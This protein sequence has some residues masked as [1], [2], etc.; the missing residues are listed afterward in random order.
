MTF[1]IVARC[2]ETGMLGMAVASS[3]PAVAA[4]C[5]HARAGVGAVASQNITDP[6]LGRAALDL[7]GDGASAAEAVA[8]LVRSQPNIAYRQLLAVDVTGGTGLFSGA[9]MLGQSG[10]AAGNGCACA[11]NLLADPKVPQAMRDAFERSTGYLA[12]RLISALEA[13]RDAGG[14]AGPVHSAGLLLV[15]AVPWPVID[16]RVDWDDNDPI[17]VLARLYRHY[18]PQLADYVTRALDPEAAPAF[19]VPGEA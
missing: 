8:I 5:A 1:S 6:R 12:G 18:R 17:E 19:G 3:S 7:M 4:R 9:K 14:E 16:L 2:A 10:E 15:D 13:A 11:G